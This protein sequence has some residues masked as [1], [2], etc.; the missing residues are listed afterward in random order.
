MEHAQS[1]SER[2]GSRSSKLKAFFQF[3]CTK[4]N[5]LNCTL[6]KIGLIR[7]SDN[8]LLSVDKPR[9]TLH[10]LRRDI[11]LPYQLKKCMIYEHVEASSYL[12]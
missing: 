12:A 10:C 6:R 3:N 9:R 1:L 7:Q 4:L 8:Q 2:S 5:V 11:P